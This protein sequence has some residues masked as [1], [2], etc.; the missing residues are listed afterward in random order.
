LSVLRK[1]KETKQ[2]VK[3]YFSRAFYMFGKDED[4][5]LHVIDSLV[6][7]EGTVKEQYN[8]R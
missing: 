2:L 6:G 3:K 1:K 5:F 8:F 7:E 4:S